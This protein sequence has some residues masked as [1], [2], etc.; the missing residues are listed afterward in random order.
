MHVPVH[1]VNS[2]RGQG[3]VLVVRTEALGCCQHAISR[4]PV[5]QRVAK[6]FDAQHTE[7]EQE[8]EEHQHGLRNHAKRGAERLQNLPNPLQELD[9]SQ[10]T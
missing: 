6:Q 8:V 1:V 7:Q 3:G 9:G 4:A 5:I 10:H 2:S